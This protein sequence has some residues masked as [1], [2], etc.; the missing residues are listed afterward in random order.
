MLVSFL[1]SFVSDL[2]N[3]LLSFF[4]PSFVCRGEF[5]LGFWT[6]KQSPSFH[7]LPHFLALSATTS[8]VFCTELLRCRCSV[9]SLAW[10]GVFAV[11]PLSGAL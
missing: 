7:Q 8:I 10:A 4:L 1:V 9:K 3:C 5:V 6:A 2:S 11:R